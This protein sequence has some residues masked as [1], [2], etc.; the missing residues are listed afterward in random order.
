MTDDAQSDGLPTAFVHFRDLVRIH[1]KQILTLDK[2]PPMHAATLLMLVACEA[3]STL[4]G[5]DDEHDVFARDLLSKRGVPY[6]VGKILFDAAPAARRAP[7]GGLARAR[8]LC[9]SLEH[10]S[11]RLTR[12]LVGPVVMRSA[13]NLPGR[14]CPRGR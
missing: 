10:L 11:D 9:H 7:V 1:V 12:A 5:K 2:K 13:K 3:L 6:H 4:L 14:E 8:Q